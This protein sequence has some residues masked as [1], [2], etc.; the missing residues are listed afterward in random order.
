MPCRLPLR[1]LPAV[2]A[3]FLSASAAAAQ[4]TWNFTDQ[5]GGGACTFANNAGNGIGNQYNCASQ[6]SGV[7]PTLRV[8][9]YNIGG[10]AAG[11]TA[12]NAAI[13]GPYSGSGIGVG[14]AIEGGTNATDPNHTMDNEGT[15][16][17]LL[18]LNFLTGSHNLRSVSLGYVDGDSDFQLLRWTGIAAPTVAGQTITQLFSSGWQLV[19]STN[20]GSAAASYTNV[21]AGNLSSQYWIIAAYNTGLGSAQGLDAGDDA[22]KVLSVTATPTQVVPEPSTYMLLGT[23]IAGLVGVARRRRMV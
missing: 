21:N 16:S 23:G 5:S 3:L 10:S 8:T 4:T 14:N 18:L 15:G 22:V 9:A 2:A 11:S 20:G 19:G 13:T 1:T 7:T 12:S 17:D 6:P